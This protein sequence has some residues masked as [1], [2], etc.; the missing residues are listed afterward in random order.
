MTA[1]LSL[2]TTYLWGIGIYLAALLLASAVA[3]GLALW[4][5]S[6]T[7]VFAAGLLPNLVICV[8][9]AIWSIDSWE[10]LVQVNVVVFALSALSWT[11]IDFLLPAGVPHLTIAGRRIVFAHLAAKGAVALLGLVVAVGVAHRLGDLPYLGLQRID[12][13]AWAASVAAI[14]ACLWD[15][16]ARFPLAAFYVLAWLLLAM[17]QIARGASPGT[18]YVWM[19]LAEWAALLLITALIGWSVRWPRVA[20]V[21]RIP[22]GGHRWSDRWFLRAQALLAAVVAGLA[23]WISTDFSFD[24]MG[25]GTAVFGLEGRACACPSALM[26]VGASIAMAW[27]STGWRRSAWQFAAMAAGVLFTTSIGWSRIDVATEL[28]WYHRSVNLMISTFMMS[29]MTWIGLPRV[30][31]RT[32][33]WVSNGRRAAPVFASIA[34][35]LATVVLIHKTL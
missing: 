19:G 17:G 6:A 10:C 28:P 34:F 7:G 35:V 25:I 3:G 5:R 16:T 20:A 21:L 26:L 11:L 30:L 2:D 14:T 18:H 23:V 8:V 4:R 27:Q 24:G 12:W 15:R 13:F 1:T 31:P 22:V 32:N 29:L 33:A 9:W